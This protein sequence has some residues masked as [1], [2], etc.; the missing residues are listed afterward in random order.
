MKTED[1]LSGFQDCFH[2]FSSNFPSTYHQL[3]ITSV[4][5][6]Q[7]T[8]RTLMD[9]GYL[10]KNI[11]LSMCYLWSSGIVVDAEVNRVDV[12]TAARHVEFR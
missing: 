2:F 10:M 1:T 3:P 11:D 9:L 7:L 5:Y 6:I 12:G 4:A 8:K